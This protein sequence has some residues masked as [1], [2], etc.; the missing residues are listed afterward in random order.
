MRVVFVGFAASSPS[1]AGTGTS[2]VVVGLRSM[3][4]AVHTS[5]SHSYHEELPE[6]NLVGVG[7]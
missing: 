2:K 4:S 6:S 3:L 7:P 5:V 1:G